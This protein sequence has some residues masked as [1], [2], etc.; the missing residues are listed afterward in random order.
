VLGLGDD[1]PLFVPRAR[2]VVEIGEEADLVAGGQMLAFG[3]FHLRPAEFVEPGVFGQADEVVDVVVIAPAQQPPAAEAGVGAENNL[4]PGP[5]LA[6]ALHQQVEDG[7]AVPGG[8]D[9]AGAKITHQ[10][11]LTAKNVEGQEA[12]VAVVTVKVAALLVAV[13]AVVG[14]VEIE[15]ELG[16]RR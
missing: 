1:A 16:R 5:G 10:Q 4:H 15:D 11:V 13:D 12:P 6:Q 2:R 7:A 8:V 3:L 9:V 14:R